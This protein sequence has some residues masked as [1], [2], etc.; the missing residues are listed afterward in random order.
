LIDNAY[1]YELPEPQPGQ[2]YFDIIAVCL[3]DFSKEA[4]KLNVP[5]VRVTPVMASAILEYPMRMQRIKR[6]A[7]VRK[8]SKKMKDRF[9]TDSPVVVGLLTTDVSPAGLSKAPAY[10]LDGQHRLLGIEA[11]LVTQNLDFV[12]RAFPNIEEMRKYALDLDSGMRR[13]HTHGAKISEIDLLLGVGSQDASAYQKAVRAIMREGLDPTL[14]YTKEDSED[15]VKVYEAAKHYQIAGRLLFN[16]L[17]FGTVNPI[18]NEAKP[19][20]LD[21]RRAI[22]EITVF[23]PLLVW[24]SKN[25]QLVR[26]FLTPILLNE[27][28]QIKPVQNTFL[29][30]LRQGLIIKDSKFRSVM[31]VLPPPGYFNTGNK[32]QRRGLMATSIM[33]ERFRN[34]H[35]RGRKYEMA[36]LAED[37]LLNVDKVIAN[38][39]TQGARIMAE[40][41]WPNPVE[42]AEAKKVA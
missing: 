3:T 7:H 25:T 21:F 32:T 11:S 14:S 42:T 9:L 20:T 10:L 5:N 1:V 16:L 37:V 18:T 35:T 23:A 19:L 34:P 31:G 27:Q 17:H 12:F 40:L 29:Q 26:L 33:L 8:L 6:N 4:G 30:F 2:S 22:R 24:T 36:D 38:A 39:Q 15:L 41:D 28:S 13:N